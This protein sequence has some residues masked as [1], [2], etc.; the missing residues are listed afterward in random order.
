MCVERFDHHC[1]W[2]NN[3]I[4]VNNHIYFI[5]FLITL[6][7]TICFIFATT[8]IELISKTK[9]KYLTA[10]DLYYNI[11]PVDITCNLIVWKLAS[12]FVLCVCG[13]FFCPV[14]LLM[15]IQ[16]RNF[17]VNRTTNERFSRRQPAKRRNSSRAS[18]VS[19][20]R[21]DSTGSSLLS[22]NPTILPED[23]IKDMAGAEDYSDKYC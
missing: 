3:C 4:G 23:I 22:Q 14:I 11:L 19:G 8:L 13:F 1:P 18:I 6:W 5:S 10:N 15:Y 20:E 2:I 7:C 17:L 9:R 21:S 12:I 16:V